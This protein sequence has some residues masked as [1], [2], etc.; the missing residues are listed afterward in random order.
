MALQSEKNL[1][2]GTRLAPIKVE[3]TETSY[4]Q[5]SESGKCLRKMAGYARI[6]NRNQEYEQVFLVLKVPPSKQFILSKIHIFNNTIGYRIPKRS[7][8]FSAYL[9]NSGS[10]I[11]IILPPMSFSDN[12]LR[13]FIYFQ[14]S[15]TKVFTN[16]PNAQHLHATNK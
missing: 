4:P 12:K 8:C 2:D 7:P 16:H 11:F 10:V 6:H 13:R 3:E 9:S 14:I 15:S 1:A 5:S